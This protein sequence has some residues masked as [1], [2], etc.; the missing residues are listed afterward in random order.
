METGVLR[1][2]QQILSNGKLQYKNQIKPSVSI[3]ITTYCYAQILSNYNVIRT[4]K[5]AK[6]KEP[7]QKRTNKLDLKVAELPPIIGN[8]ERIPT[9]S[10]LRECVKFFPNIHF[11]LT[12]VVAFITQRM[13]SSTC[14]AIS[15]TNIGLE[16]VKSGNKCFVTIPW[17]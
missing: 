1:Q 14:F 13:D 10:S 11:K 2:H 9:F 3:M 17:D 6:P 8:F 4:N 16:Q 12:F 5:R 15:N 7:D